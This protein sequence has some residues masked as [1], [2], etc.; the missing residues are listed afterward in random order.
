MFLFLHS[1]P[2]LHRSSL[3]TH[4]LQESNWLLPLAQPSGSCLIVHYSPL[5]TSWLSP[6]S[7]SINTLVL[8][9]YLCILACVVT[10]D[11]TKDWTQA[12]EP[13]PLVA[14]DM[15]EELVNTVRTTLMP[16]PASDFT[17]IPSDFWK[18]LVKPGA[19]Q[20]DIHRGSLQYQNW[21]CFFVQTSNSQS[22]FQCFMNEVFP[23]VPQSVKELQP[24]LGFANFYS[25]IRQFSLLTAP[26]HLHAAW[27]ARVSVLGPRCPRSL[28]AYQGSIQHGPHPSS[29]SI[30]K[31]PL[32]SM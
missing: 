14:A 3:S 9:T 4:L 18:M 19:S 10:E 28:P 12:M 2:N 15:L 8:T 6:L 7:L 26:P 16:A 22:V 24:L 11:R 30:L 29:P 17:R 20:D 27:Q 5:I 21:D 1:A 25:F 23:G 13:R 32:Y 31:S